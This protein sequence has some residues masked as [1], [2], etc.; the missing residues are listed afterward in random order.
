MEQKLKKIYTY[1]IQSGLLD[2]L[3]FKKDI[4]AY[5]K[6]NTGNIIESRIDEIMSEHTRLLKDKGL[7]AMSCGHINGM[8]KNIDEI[9]ENKKIQLHVIMSFVIG[10][11]NETIDKYTRTGYGLK[12]V[13]D[14]EVVTQNNFEVVNSD[15]ELFKYFKTRNKI[16]YPYNKMIDIDID[17]SAATLYETY[18]WYVALY[19]H[20][21]KS[22]HMINN[23]YEID[24]EDVNHLNDAYH[25]L[26]NAVKE[27][28]KYHN[29]ILDNKIDYFKK[30][31]ALEKTLSR[32]RNVLDE[33]KEI[34][35]NEKGRCAI[36]YE[37]INT[38]TTD[39]I[40]LFLKENKFNYLDHNYE[41]YTMFESLI[42]LVS[43]LRNTQDKDEAKKKLKKLKKH[44]L[45]YG[46]ICDWFE[47]D[48]SYFHIPESVEH[49]TNIP[50]N[51][52]F[53]YAIKFYKRY[54]DKEGEDTRELLKIFFSNAMTLSDTNF[55]HKEYMD[56][57]KYDND[58][59]PLYQMQ[60]LYPTY[61][62]KDF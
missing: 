6:N 36:A 26:F 55:A 39:D 12:V 9:L 15:D 28:K 22:I 27:R 33:A 56:L 47:V 53:A 35:N 57:Y 40:L 11:L 21:E 32:L 23:G 45:E 16:M 37:N 24:S 62:F 30:R 3:K 25:Y 51:K 58:G 4:H 2:E 34:E 13:V 60:F 41:S 42:E 61:I 18:M 17:L 49:H 52:V 5:C 59:L 48:N 29:G 50:L 20:K 46:N 38:Y 43:V 44:G 14:E 8:D 54:Y 1:F 7:Y 31:K 10:K 19:N